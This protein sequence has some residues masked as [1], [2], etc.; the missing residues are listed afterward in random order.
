MG[1]RPATRDGDVVER[2]FVVAERDLVWIMKANRALKRAGAVRNALIQ[3]VSALRKSERLKEH[4]VLQQRDLVRERM[5]IQ[6]ARELL[7]RETFLTLWEMVD[8][9]EAAGRQSALS[10]APPAEGAS[11]RQANKP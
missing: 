1:S 5:F 6:A 11:F 7:D 2:I 9:R 3:R 10:T 4:A 8:Q